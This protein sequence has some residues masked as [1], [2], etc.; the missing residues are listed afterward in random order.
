M[1]MISQTL[2]QHWFRMCHLTILTSLTTK[3]VVQNTEWPGLSLVG[4]QEGSEHTGQG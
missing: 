1:I 2:V 4:P 3:T